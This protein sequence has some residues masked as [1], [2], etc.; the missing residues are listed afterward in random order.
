M[1]ANS[2]PSNTD[3]PALSVRLAMPADRDFIVETIIG[4][5][6][7]GTDRLSYCT[8]FDLEECKLRRLLA[9]LV[10]EDI[11]GQELC[12]SGYLIAEV[13]GQRAGAT[14]SWIEGRGAKSSAIVK[15]NLLAHAFGRERVVASAARLELIAPLTMPRE[16]GALQI[17]SVYVAS[18]WRGRGIVRALINEHLRH[19]GEREAPPEKCQ[20]IV[21]ANNYAAIRIYRRFGF[22]I[23]ATR[24]SDHAVLAQLL[25]ANARAQMTKHLR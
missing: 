23:T 1:N 8:L 14:C 5:E 20:I 18:P 7:S 9:E 19:A 22:E 2:M 3:V 16:A 25:P 11:P 15:G 6:K 24:S 12:I 10:D 21:A 4:A 17:E 13:D